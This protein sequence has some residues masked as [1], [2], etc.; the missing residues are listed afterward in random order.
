MNAKVAPPCIFVLF[1]A[2]GDLTARLVF[3]A[4][5]NL[6]TQGLL[7][8]EFA[9]VGIARKEADTDGFRKHLR[10]SLDKFAGRKI[11]D[12]IAADIVLLEQHGLVQREEELH[13]GKTLVFATLTKLGRDVANGRPHPMV[14]QPSPK[15]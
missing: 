2:T 6:A 7:P 9:I 14:D 1:G 12:T 13:N 4:I 11:D 5:Y 3:P 15:F 8:K 10:D